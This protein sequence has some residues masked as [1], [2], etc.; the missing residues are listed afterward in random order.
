VKE[1]PFSEKR[2]MSNIK[3]SVFLFIILLLISLLAVWILYINSDL[4]IK[5][6]EYFSCKNLK[7]NTNENLEVIYPKEYGSIFLVV[8]L[9]VPEY[10]Y[11]PNESDYLKIKEEY[12]NTRKSQKKSMYG[13]PST[14]L[15]NMPPPHQVYDR[16]PGRYTINFSN[17]NAYQADFIAR[18]RDYSTDQITFD[19]GGKII[20]FNFD[21]WKWFKLNF[22]KRFSSVDTI[23]IAFIVQEHDLELPFKIQFDNNKPIEIKSSPKQI[24]NK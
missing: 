17:N 4:G 11:I 15:P 19:S 2:N 6:I 18:W 7:K 24:T 1:S 20:S 12:E 8:V 3:K 13:V 14:P 10:Y 21:F 9:A 16:N 22:A 5:P 23:A